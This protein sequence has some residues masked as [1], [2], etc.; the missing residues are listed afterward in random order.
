[1]GNRNGSRFR[2]FYRE[3]VGYIL[4]RLDAFYKEGMLPIETYLRICE[5]TGEDPDPMKMPPDRSEFPIEVQEAFLLHDF[6]PD[7]W[8]EGGYLGK[9][10]SSLDSL[11]NV[12]NIEEKQQVVIFL[13]HIDARNMA[14]INK[15]LERKRKSAES[16]KA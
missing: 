12:F 5:Q 9:N 8:I 1:M 11:L 14:K 4:A 13:K 6:L 3:Q 10:Y 15:E 16:K 7:T 2:K